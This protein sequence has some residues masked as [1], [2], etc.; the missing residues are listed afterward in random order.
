MFYCPKNK[1]IEKHY[2]S[3]TNPKL[4]MIHQSLIFFCKTSIFTW[5]QALEINYIAI[6]SLSKRSKVSDHV[7]GAHR[8]QKIISN[9]SLFFTY[10]KIGGDPLVKF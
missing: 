7:F 10:L 2:Y 8:F 9:G 3:Y 4:N 6:F 1:N 5:Y